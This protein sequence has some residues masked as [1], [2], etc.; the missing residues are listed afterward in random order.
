MK[1]II[2][3]EELGHDVVG[4]LVDLCLK[5]IHLLE[6]IRRSGMTFGK[7]CDSDAET[8]IVRV[9][10]E[11]AN[12][13]DQVGGLLKGVVGLVV[14]CEVA[15]WVAPERENVADALAGVASQDVSDIVFLMAD[16]GEMWDRIERGRVFQP[17]HEIVG[18][19]TCRASGT[20]GDAD[21]MGIV[22][23]QFGNRLVEGFRS[24]F[25]L[26]REKFEGKR[27]F[28]LFPIYPECAFSRYCCT[29]P[30]SRQRLFLF[31]KE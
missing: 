7:A 31:W 28:P 11:V 23:F 13:A 15:R 9:T 27:R 10:G 20:V 16:T 30:E 25:A 29:I 26:G 6:S 12:V 1:I 21:K 3:K 4:T 5:V 22:G 17:D 2:V 19:L 8:A 18:Q 24:G 14:V